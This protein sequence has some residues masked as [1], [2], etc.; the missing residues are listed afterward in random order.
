MDNAYDSRAPGI[1]DHWFGVAFRRLI[2]PSSTDGFVMRLLSTPVLVRVAL[3]MIVVATMSAGSDAVGQVGDTRLSPVDAPMYVLDGQAYGCAAARL[4]GNRLA[5]WGTTVPLFPDSA[6]M[7]GIVAAIVHADTTATAP[8]LITSSAARLSVTMAVVHLSD[9]FIVLWNDRRADA[10]GAYMQVVDTLGAPSGGEQGLSTQRIAQ[11]DRVWVNRTGT[12]YV[13]T[14]QSN[15]SDGVHFHQRALTAD[16]ILS[17]PA[18]EIVT[19]NFDDSLTFDALPG[20]VIIRDS[21]NGCRFIHADGRVDARAIPSPFLYR[22]HYLGADTSIVVLEPAGS[23]KRWVTFYRSPFDT[24]VVR[25]VMITLPDGPIDAASLAADSLGRPLVLLNAD[26]RSGGG[27]SWGHSGFLNSY[28][29][30]DDGTL[31]DSQFVAYTYSVTYEDRISVTVEGGLE[32]YREEWG[33]NNSIRLT[34]G[35]W[36]T[37]TARPSGSKTTSHAKEI[38]TID[39]FGRAYMVDPAVGAYADSSIT[40]PVAVERRLVPGYSAVR[41]T[42]DGSSSR[43]LAVPIA[44]TPQHFAHTW[45]ALARFGDTVVVAWRTSKTIE[46]FGG[47]RWFSGVPGSGGDSML[48]FVDLQF[49]ELSSV[50]I[51]FEH[52]GVMQR[53]NDFFA[54]SYTSIAGGAPLPDG[55]PNPS[56]AYH[57]ALPSPWG[58][59][60]RYVVGTRCNPTQG[61]H[62]YD[63]DSGFVVGMVDGCNYDGICLNLDRTGNV[64][65]L[66]T[67]GAGQYSSAIIPFSGGGY[68]LVRN[69]SALAFTGSH[70]DRTF[71]LPR[72][73]APG[74]AVYQRLHG[75][76]FLRCYPEQG[77]D[78]AGVMR[79]RRIV[80]ETLDASGRELSRA[81]VQAPSARF[82]LFAYERAADSVLFVVFGSDDGV[83]LA[84]LDARLRVL[85]ADTVV[86]ATRGPVSRPVCSVR[87]DTMLV[88][89]EDYRNVVPDIYGTKLDIGRLNSIAPREGGPSIE[90]KRLYPVPAGNSIVVEYD[91]ADPTHFGV[92]LFDLLGRR[93]GTAEPIETSRNSWRAEISLE[94]LPGGAY[95]VAVGPTGSGDFVS[96]PFI[97]R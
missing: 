28:R 43:D 44:P 88:A 25:R 62:G 39:R 30:A 91:A 71:P 18:T 95:F 83:H 64:R 96:R 10:P 52:H 92:Q 21:I 51:P 72:R 77:A 78:S 29:L 5:A 87:D 69:D 27:Y 31:V 54:I 59:G 97:H 46:R 36:Q 66:D 23:F 70:L 15:E 40:Q 26:R 9:R 63:P 93:L 38:I 65:R 49:P 82:D 80:L 11:A 6:Y 81:R 73:N 3:S 48:S 85:V 79:D 33:D 37:T 61:A 75:D 32:N 74:P 84:K 8:V 67:L 2:L 47:A 35:M 55:K 4:G 1:A 89:W 42:L 56:F 60:S 90:L 14:W 58:L 20:A 53:W 50:L 12:G 13:L 22:A 17:G 16:G 24:A 19:G 94:G 7:N 76:R 41:L 68:I 34:Y 57:V 86:S 45:P